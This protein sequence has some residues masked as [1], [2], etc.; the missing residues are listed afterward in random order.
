RARPCP[1]AAH[2][3]ACEASRGSPAPGPC[4]GIGPGWPARP[5][6]SP[7]EPG[8]AS[9]RA[10]VGGAGDPA[11][12]VPGPGSRGR[13]LRRGGGAPG[14]MLAGPHKTPPHRP[15][16]PHHHGV[17]P[18]PAL[19]QVERDTRRPPPR[20]PQPPDLSKV[21]QHVVH[22]FRAEGRRPPRRVSA[23]GPLVVG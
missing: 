17:I 9:P 8:S 20:P 19:A 18:H 11:G 3:T 7:A 2:S 6:R 15:P 13:D 22:V 5:R 10:C 23:D 21:D 12:L 16:P 1:A 4:A 14:E